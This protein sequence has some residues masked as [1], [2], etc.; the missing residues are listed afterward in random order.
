MTDA[1]L[2]TAE[3]VIASAEEEVHTL[4]PRV[5]EAEQFMQLFGRDYL[6]FDVTLQRAQVLR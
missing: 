6:T 3:K 1:F 2:R 5:K 4:L